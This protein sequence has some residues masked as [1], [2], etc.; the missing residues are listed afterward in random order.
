MW[1]FTPIPINL[2]F[3]K[4]FLNTK[5]RKHEQNILLH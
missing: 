4:D 2:G 5:G 1:P 3:K